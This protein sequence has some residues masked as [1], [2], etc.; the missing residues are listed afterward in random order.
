MAQGHT[1]HPTLAGR[2]LWWRWTVATA[3]GELLG[4]AVPAAAAPFLMQRLGAL[5]DRQRAL[6]LLP[7][8]ILAGLVEGAVLAGGQW[9]VLRRAL[10]TIAARAWLLPTAL[11]AGLAYLLGM[12]P[13]TLA[14]LGASTAAVI[15]AGLLVSPLLLASIGLAQ[16]TALR[17]HLPRAG[18]WVPANAA[19]WLAGLPL[20]FIGIALVPDGSPIAAYVAAGVVS[21]WLMGAVVGAITGLALVHLLDRSRTAG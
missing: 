11:A 20:T 17:R 14:D 15:A 10:P 8:L 6:I 7:L 3:T 19:A 5:P 18:W 12:T 4:F 9:L 21:G 13:S 2:A 1:S 16:W